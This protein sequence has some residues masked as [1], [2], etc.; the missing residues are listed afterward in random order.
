MIYD[1]FRRSAL[2]DSLDLANFE[3][4]DSTEERNAICRKVYRTP[5]WSVIK[6]NLVKTKRKTNEHTESQK[7]FYYSVIRFSGIRGEDARENLVLRSLRARSPQQMTLVQ[8]GLLRAVIESI[9]WIQETI[10]NRTDLVPHDNPRRSIFR[11][12]GVVILFTE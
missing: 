12:V 9:V 5:W 4:Y 7:L 2:V 1:V 6:K 3:V 8:D 10:T 11:I